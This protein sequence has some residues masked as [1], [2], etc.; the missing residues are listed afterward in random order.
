MAVTDGA[1]GA[2]AAQV[3]VFEQTAARIRELN[4]RV[5]EVALASGGRTLE[6]YERALE[7]LLS[8]GETSGG[9]TPL[10][11]VTALAQMQADFV[12]DVST[13]YTVALRVLL[14]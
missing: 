7:N 11:W 2:L 9:A 4:E 5:L 12:R 1:E 3:D 8:V 13:A 14:G 6:A 10:E